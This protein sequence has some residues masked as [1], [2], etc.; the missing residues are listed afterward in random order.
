MARPSSFRWNSKRRFGPARPYR[1][2]R[3]DGVLYVYLHGHT[4]SNICHHRAV[5]HHQVEH[6]RTFAAADISG[7]KIAFIARICVDL[8]SRSHTR[9]Q[10]KAGMDYEYAVGADEPGEMREALEVGILGSVDVEMVGVS[11]RYHCHGRRE[12]M[13]RAVVFVGLYHREI[14]MGV[15]DEVGAVIAEHTA[16]EGVASGGRVVEHVGGHG[17]CGGLAVGACETEATAVARNNAEHGG[18][19]HH[20]ETVGAEP[21][22][23]GM[24]IGHGG[25]VDHQCLPGIAERLRNGFG[26]IAVGNLHA[27]AFKSAGEVG[28]GAVIPTHTLS[29]AEEITFKSRHAYA[30]GSHKVYVGTICCHFFSSII[31]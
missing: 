23:P 4:G 6:Y 30:A 12:M 25:S 1:G 29:L 8:H 15:K 11:G 19:F 14:G 22:Q 5:G 17:R 26:G 10:F 16:K 3:G 9:T 21:L 27:L 18:T 20:L 28:G 2:E 31:R 7:V 13:E 24:R